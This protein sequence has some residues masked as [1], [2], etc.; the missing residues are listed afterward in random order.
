MSGCCDG[1]GYLT[2]KRIAEGMLQ[3]SQE[4]ILRFE[5]VRRIFYS[6]TKVPIKDNWRLRTSNEIWLEIVSQV[7]VVGR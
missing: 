3:I 6:R 5:Q 7:V 4:H 2:I 1:V